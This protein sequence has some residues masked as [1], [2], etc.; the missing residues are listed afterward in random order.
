MEW[1]GF[2]KLKSRLLLFL[3]FCLVEVGYGQEE[4]SEKLSL[5]SAVELALQ[6]NEQVLISRNDVK[7]ARARIREAWADALPE[8]NFNGLYTRNIKRPVIFLPGFFF[9]DHSPD[10]QVPVEIGSKNAYSF[11]F[12]FDQAIYQAGK[13]SAGIRAARL[14]NRYSNAGFAATRGDVTL[15]VKIAFYTILLNQQL[16]EINRQSLEQSLEHLINSRKLFLEGQVAELDTLRAWVDYVNLQPTVIWAENNLKMSENHFKE[17]IGLE[18][19]EPITLDGQLA[20]EAG[21]G[22][23]YDQYL[24]QALQNRPE[25]RQL[26]FQTG[27]YK[28]NV[29]VTRSDLLPKLSFRGV[30]QYDAQS[31]RFDFG[32]G[33]QNAISAAVRLEVPIFNGFRSYAKIQQAKLDYANSQLQVQMFKDRLK[34]E[35]ESILLNLQEAAKRVYAQ[36]QAIVQAEKA[37]YMAERQYNEGVG[38]RIEIGDARLA[39]NLTKTNYIRAV[40]DHKVALAELDKAIGRE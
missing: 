18:L 12:T 22:V 11:F 21:D 36:Q 4:L 31:E 34:I 30:Y 28:E 35:V 39:L 20:F 32:P 24:E 8:I 7:F 15:A 40:Y 26:E 13:V 1:R 38:T 3:L 19:Q 5:Q 27:I 37:L 2:M 25:L 6:K 14:Y 33:L 23:V 9:P 29:T 16:L 10:E 17:L